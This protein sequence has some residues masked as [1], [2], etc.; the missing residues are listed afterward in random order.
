MLE[1]YK[2]IGLFFVFLVLISLV[3][4]VPPQ[5]VVV[6]DF[7]NGLEI[8]Y[9]AFRV[10]KQ[11]EDFEFNFHVYNKSDGYPISSE[12]SCIFHLFNG[13]DGTHIFE[14][15]ENE[16]DSDLDYS[17]ELDAGNFT[18]RGD[19][20]YLISCNDSVKGGF[21]SVP[22]EVTSNGNRIIN[23]PIVPAIII[24]LPM[25]LSFIFLIG[26]VSLK[27]TEHAI[28]KTFLFLFAFIPFIVSLHFGAITLVEYYDMPELQEAMGNTIFWFTWLFF[29]GIVAYFILY[30]IYVLFRGMQE[31]KRIRMEY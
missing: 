20:C 17:F 18:N 28:L 12:I 14:G 4:A 31:K 5:S 6:G 2:R 8:K 16:S 25:I 22:F 23:N 9:P 3:F 15:F 13:S 21:V 1:Y 26:A 24:L 27:E 10:I 7:D 29:F 19:Y 30:F 11:S